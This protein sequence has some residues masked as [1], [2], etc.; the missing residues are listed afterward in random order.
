MKQEDQMAEEKGEFEFGVQ[1]FGRPSL[2]LLRWLLKNLRN[3][4]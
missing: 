3:K 4:C 1:Y 2:L